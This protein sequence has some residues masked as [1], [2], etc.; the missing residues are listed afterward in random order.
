MLIYSVCNVNLFG[1]QRFYYYVFSR[2]HEKRAKVL[3]FSHIR[4]QKQQNFFI[5]FFSLSN[6]D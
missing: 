2:T 5:S 3:K 1:L 4:K 6:I